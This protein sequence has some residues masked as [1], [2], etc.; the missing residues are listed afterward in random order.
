[1]ALFCKKNQKEEGPARASPWPLR[2]LSQILS[3]RK[4]RM[5]KLLSIGVP[6]TGRMPMYL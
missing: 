2:C 4:K 3:E 5:L 1:M 6:L